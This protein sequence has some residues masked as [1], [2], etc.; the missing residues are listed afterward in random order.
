MFY[1]P[2]KV[3]G[4]IGQ[5]VKWINTWFWQ[6]TPIPFLVFWSNIGN[7]LQDGL[8]EKPADEI[9][10]FPKMYTTP[11]AESIMNISKPSDLWGPFKY[12][13]MFSLGGFEDWVLTCLLLDF[14]FLYELIYAFKRDEA[15][16]WT[17]GTPELNN[18]ID[19][20]RLG[21]ADEIIEETI[22]KNSL[23]YFQTKDGIDCNGNSGYGYYCYCPS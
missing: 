1:K 8:E 11:L 20:N 2:M 4:W 15:N 17:L 14:V 18:H 21:P 19:M 9:G 10:T 5:F 3:K 6:F 7:Y 13:D 16:N 12:Y 22:D 23:E